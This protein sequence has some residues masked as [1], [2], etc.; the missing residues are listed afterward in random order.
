MQVYRVKTNMSIKKVLKL[1][2]KVFTH[3][4]VNLKTGAA[5]YIETT[6]E[7][8]ALKEKITLLKSLGH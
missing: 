3:K 7:D 1:A 8:T 5:T 6:I 2:G 4:V